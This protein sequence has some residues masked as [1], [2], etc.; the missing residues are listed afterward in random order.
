M[1]SISSFP[2]VQ[3]SLKLVIKCGVSLSISQYLQIQQSEMPFSALHQGVN[4]ILALKSITVSFI[5]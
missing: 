1:T 2:T 3:T 5:F 4:D